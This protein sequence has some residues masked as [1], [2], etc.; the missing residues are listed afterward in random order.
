MWNDLMR[1]WMELAFWW[2]PGQGNDQAP[3]SAQARKSRPAAG[4]DAGAPEPEAAPAQEP[5]PA[6]AE[7]SGDLKGIKGIG[8]AMQ[9]RLAGLGITG[10]SALARADA[11]ALTEQLKAGKA[12]ISRAQVERWIK[13]AGE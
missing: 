9:K 11:D 2:L 5:T 10:R 7:A 6:P 4:R 8:P 13:A 12:V 1:R 3:S